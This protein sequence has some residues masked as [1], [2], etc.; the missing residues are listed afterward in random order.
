MAA[1]RVI[2]LVLD[3]WS[4]NFL[5]PYGN[6]WVETSTL[7]QLARDSL[8]IEHALTDT[9]DL[10]SV[11]ASYWQGRHAA[12]PTKPTAP[13]LGDL[14][15]DRNLR[16]HLITDEPL[17]AHHPLAV[18]QSSVTFVELPMIDQSADDWTQTQL[19]QFLA[20]VA[21][22]LERDTADCLWIHARA[23]AGPWDAPYRL[24]MA[25]S[26]DEDPE[27]PRFVLPPGDWHAAGRH[28]HGSRTDDFTADDPDKAW[29]L[30]RAYAAQVM[31]VDRCLEFF[32][33]MLDHHAIWGNALMLL[34][35][36]R[37]YPLGEHLQVGLGQPSLFGELLHVPLFV[38]RPDT[39][40]VL[41]RSR[42]CVQPPSVFAT[43]LDWLGID[44]AQR[45]AGARS[46]MPLF[47]AASCLATENAK[48]R[49][50]TAE[51]HAFDRAVSVTAGEQSLHTPGWF[52][53]R[54]ARVPADSHAAAHQHGC[55]QA[56]YVKP[57]DRWEANE[58]ADRCPAVVESMGHTLEEFLAAAATESL[59][60]LPPLPSELMEAAF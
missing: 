42:V 4:A 16:T 46:V 18:R 13:S 19:A 25:L 39:P 47:A 10:E 22:T 11:Y 30:A 28:S 44:S 36:P 58:I 32:C 55:G 24:R 52:L 29:G 26:D 56:L 20:S 45:G 38:R 49:D 54:L 53:R 1:S 57:D 12:C 34:T 23:F 3:G 2:V 35:S 8:L 17:I 15:A 60:R 7:N 59:D 14:L 41:L 43:V 27:P 51:T 33:E 5:G 37:G 50:E 9:P 31:V 40:G 21:E 48:E 6:T